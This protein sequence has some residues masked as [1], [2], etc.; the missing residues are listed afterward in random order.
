MK[1]PKAPKLV[2]V[3]IFTTITIIFW[4]FFSLYKVFTSKDP[5]TVDPKLLETLNPTLD[6]QTL[7]TLKQKTFFREGE[8]E[9][10]AIVVSPTP[11]P[12]LD[13]EEVTQEPGVATNES[14]VIVP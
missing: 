2:T 12:T 8:F 11:S 3:A 1:K 9:T 7:G 4:V 14:E 6:T 10:T 13:V 5:V